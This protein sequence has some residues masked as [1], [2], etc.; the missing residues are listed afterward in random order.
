MTSVIAMSFI[1]LGDC[2]YVGLGHALLP[3]LSVAKGD[4]IRFIWKKGAALKIWPRFRCV[5]PVEIVRSVAA[6]IGLFIDLRQLHAAM[7][8]GC[9]MISEAL[10]D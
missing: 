4:A 6:Y 8:S 3:L 2:K 9:R 5:S 1:L 10:T 7:R